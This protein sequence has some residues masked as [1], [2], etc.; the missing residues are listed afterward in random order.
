MGSALRSRVLARAVCVHSAGVGS[1]LRSQ[2]RSP[3]PVLWLQMLV[4]RVQ[5]HSTQSRE[6]T[7]VWLAVPVQFCGTQPVAPGALS[8]LRGALYPGAVVTVPCTVGSTCF[9][10]HPCYQLPSTLTCHSLIYSFVRQSY[11]QR[12][13][14]TSIHWSLPKWPQ[15]PGQ[16]GRSQELHPGSH[17]VQGPEHPAS[18]LLSRLGHS[19]AAGTQGAAP[20]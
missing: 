6:D 1:A 9:C 3:F 17:V 15:Q 14:D 2:V 13:S 10:S 20:V 12:G 5:N 8:D 18:S 4:P 16:P 19:G 11:R 7:G